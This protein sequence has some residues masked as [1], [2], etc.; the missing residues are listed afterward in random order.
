VYP[1]KVRLARARWR[2]TAAGMARRS[3]ALPTRALCFG[4]DPR[5]PRPLREGRRRAALRR[6]GRLNRAVVAVS[7]GP[8]TGIGGRA[9]T[10]RAARPRPCV[11]LDKESSRALFFREGRAATASHVHAP[12]GGTAVSRRTCMCF[13]FHF[14]SFAYARDRV[15]AALGS[16]SWYLHHTHLPLSRVGRS[17]YSARNPRQTTKTPK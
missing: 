1:P 16:C 11:N 8:R 17:A 14:D 6:D 5:V 4:P 10:R 9:R 7:L 3:A 13:H 2:A 15:S 12:S